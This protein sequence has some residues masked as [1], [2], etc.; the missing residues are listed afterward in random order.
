MNAIGQ[1]EEVVTFRIPYDVQRRLNRTP[2]ELGRDLRLYGALMLF[3][4]GKL[5][6]GAAAELAGVPKVLFLDLCG[7]YNIAVS[8]ITP[9]ELRTEIG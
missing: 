4:L 5:S 6:A 1:P 7:Q 3:Q 8:Q 9:D 2:D